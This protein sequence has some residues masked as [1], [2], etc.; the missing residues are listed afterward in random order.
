LVKHEDTRVYLQLYIPKY[1]KENINEDKARHIRIKKNK[2]QHLLFMNQSPVIHE[3]LIITIVL[4]ISLM[5]SCIMF[6]TIL[7]M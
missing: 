7:K 3:A 2:S 4:D 5:K 1:H 6:L